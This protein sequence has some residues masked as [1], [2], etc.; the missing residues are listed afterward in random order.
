VITGNFISDVDPDGAG[1]NPRVFNYSG[2]L[3]AAF[4]SIASLGTGGCG[5]EQ[6]L[7]AMKAALNNNPVNNTFLRAGAYLAVIV[8]ADED[9]CSAA[10]PNFFGPESPQLGPLDSFRCFEK[11][12]ECNEGRDTELRD[13]GIKTACAIDDSQTYL[14]KIEEYVTFL[15]GLKPDDRD[16]IVG[17]II[18]PTEPVEVGRRTPPMSTT[19]RPDLIP[20]CSYC[21][22][23]LDAMG[24]CPDPT[25]NLST[26]DPAFRLRAFFESFVDRNTF[27]TIC[28]ND[29]TDAL[30]QIAE[31]LRTVI[32]YPCIEAD[33]SDSDGDPSNGVQYECQFSYVTNPG[34]ADES[35]QA[36]P[37]CDAS[38]S[39]KPCW[40]LIED[41]VNCTTSS[42]HLSVAVERD[43]EPAP[44][45]YIKGG[46]V[47]N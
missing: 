2:T 42:H 32:G 43:T 44:N 28:D 14:H 34:E 40:R 31:L 4:T 11:A 26:A 37:E 24:N 10:Q 41:L 36:L 27:T 12:V 17:G 6:H 7:E 20:S 18:S 29:Y 47:V 3:A 23:P 21:E 5:F 19:P 25:N 22:V 15:K 33:L 8:I 45:T 46:C 9:D 30:V 38:L 13:V 16:V 1:P 39:N 35:E